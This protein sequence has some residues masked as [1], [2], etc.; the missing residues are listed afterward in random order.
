MD[1]PL[2]RVVAPTLVSEPEVTRPEAS[3]SGRPWRRVISTP[4]RHRMA[5]I[6]ASSLCI[7]TFTSGFDTIL[8][9][10]VT[11]ELGYSAGDWAQL[12]SLRFAG[13]LVGVLVLGILSDR[14]GTR[15]FGVLGLW[16]GGLLA[17]LAGL[18]GGRGLGI[19]IPVL[20]ALVS[21]A[22]VNLNTLTQLVTEQRAGLANS[23]YRSVGA[24]ATIVAPFLATAL[25]GYWG[26]YPLVFVVLGACMLL[27]GGVLLRH[28]EV[29]PPLA[30]APFREEMRRLG[31]V[32][33]AAW[34]VRPL[35]LVIVAQAV[36]FGLM[37]ASVSFAAIRLTRQLPLSDQEFG[38]LASV[39]G[40]L[41]LG[42]ILLSTR[43][44][45]RSR[46]HYLHAICGSA[47]SVCILVMGWGRSV[48]LAMAGFLGSAALMGM[49]VGPLSLWVARVAGPCSLTSAF[50]VHKLVSAALLSLAILLMGVVESSLGLN[51]VFLL[52]GALGILLAPCFAF[53]PEGRS[54]QRNP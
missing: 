43:W 50:A 27:A 28:P 2:E 47:M 31:K 34:A 20:G 41:G 44:L 23:I 9:L 49:M 21:T 45:D 11:R 30:K 48:P 32:Y 54:P 53:F 7:S 5:I 42:C 35:I 36:Y 6:A 12:R 25:A 10:Y 16:G 3:E 26:G 46:L 4:A 39:G 40:A 24:G 29:N 14:F 13:V 19:I 37:G 18:L 52:P 22:F 38:V 1:E 15:K 8:P 51:A 33:Q 17:I